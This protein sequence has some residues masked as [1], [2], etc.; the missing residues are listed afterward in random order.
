MQAFVILTEKSC[1]KNKLTCIFGIS[2][3]RIATILSEDKI[4]SVAA[5]NIMVFNGVSKTQSNIFL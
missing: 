2:F 1:T 5:F 4:E 3:Q